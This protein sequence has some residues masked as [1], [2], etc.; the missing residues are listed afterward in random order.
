M[1]S[2]LFETTTRDTSISDT[3]AL[4]APIQKQQTNTI[5]QKSK[6]K[7]H[8]PLPSSPAETNTT[9]NNH[10]PN[11]PLHNNRQP[12]LHNPPTHPL[13]RN[14]NRP[15]NRPLHLLP[16][17]IRIPPA[18]APLRAGAHNERRLRHGREALLRRAA[19]DALRVA[20]GGCQGEAAGAGGCWCGALLW[21]ARGGG[22]GGGDY[23]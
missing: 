11:A 13:D 6:S 14:P 22:G 20:H 12:T 1:A 21:Q 19:R 5:S 9:S 7:L 16:R 4:T 10:R 15:R 2:R 3:M 8:P 17:A 18:L 23:R